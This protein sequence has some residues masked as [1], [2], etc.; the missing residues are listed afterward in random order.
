[1][2]NSVI[3]NY[4]QK[5]G[6]NTVSTDYYN[7]IEIWENWWKNCVDFHKYHDSSNKERTMH[8][9]GMAKRLA[10]DWASIVLS[11]RDEIK[12]I[13]KNKT[14]TDKNNKYLEKQM[15]ELN[16]Y[17]E[18]Q[19]AVEKSAAMGTAGSVLRVKH[20]K[21]ENGVIVPTQRTK[22]DII[23]L[24]ASQ[25]VPLKV[26]HGKIIDVAFISEDI[27][28]GKTQYY[29]EIHEKVWD[30]KLEIE[31]YVITNTYLNEDGNE[32]EKEG[33]LKSYSFNSDIPLFSICK[34]PIANPLEIDYKTNG[35]GYSMYGNAIDQLKACDIAYHNFVM[36]F[37]LGG[38]KVFY[39]KKIVSKKSKIVDGKEI[40]VDVYPDDIT[41]Q[42]WATYG[43]EMENVSKDDVIKEYNPD[44]RVD[45]DTKGIQF[46]LDVLSFKAALG[47]KY[48]QFNTNGTVTATQYV[49]DRQDLVKNAKKYRKNVNSFVKNICRGLLLLGRVLFNEPVTEN[50]DIEVVDQDGFLVDTE[51]AKAEFRK[52]I[53]QGIR[54]QWEYRVKFLGEDEETAKA[55]I[56]DEELEDFDNDD[57]HNKNNSKNSNDNKQKE[58][59]NKKEE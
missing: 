16:L 31:K 51:T 7:F 56:A 22:T 14:Q 30:K 29:I 9:L 27:V 59:K 49:G 57:I 39:N 36:D 12:S 46:C 8:T 6:Y 25:I 23:Y 5:K 1:M 26:E 34:T 15:E 10:E 42:Q 38:K 11:E 2:N 48:Y 4:L 28:K 50:C 37:Y 45:D 44:L 17:D 55:M 40:L 58:N 43:D 33:V 18:I 32:I 19:E 47:M 21:V 24:Y 54:K 13:A 41:R 35:M 52:D 3:L 20:I 53:A